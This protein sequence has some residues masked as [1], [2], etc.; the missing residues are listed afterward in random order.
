MAVNLRLFPPYIKGD[1]FF[2]DILMALQK[3]E[4]HCSSCRSNHHHYYHRIQKTES[5]WSIVY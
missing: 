5:I 2:G 3:E 1:S 4:E